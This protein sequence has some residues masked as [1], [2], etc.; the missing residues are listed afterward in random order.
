MVAFHEILDLDDKAQILSAVICSKCSL[1][2]KY[3]SKTTGTNHI[4]KHR[5]L[6][7]DAN[8]SMDGFVSIR[9]VNI[10]SND[11]NRIK[12]AATNFIHL[13]IYD[14]LNPSMV[15]VFLELVKVF[16]YIGAKYGNLSDN[17]LR[18]VI[19]SPQTISR[20]VS[21]KAISIKANSHTFIKEITIKRGLAMTMNL[22]TDSIRRVSYLSLTAHYI[23]ETSNSEL[24]LNEH[25]LC[26]II[27][28]YKRK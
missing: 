18:N 14:H 11:K 9:N 1:I 3:N 2:Y 12:K 28:C 7:N 5:C 13:K 21:S 16:I 15:L 10:L 8:P 19:P 6:S 4:L 23:D 27:V 25:I 22:W 26:L 17:D 24:K 20:N